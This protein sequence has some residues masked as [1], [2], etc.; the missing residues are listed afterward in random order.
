ME[1]N[2]EQK[3]GKESTNIQVGNISVGLDYND[4]KSICKDIY[5]SELNKLAI[6]AVEIAESRLKEFIDEY[7]KKLSNEKIYDLDEI[8]NPDVQFL[9]YEAQNGYIR[10]GSKSLLE[11]LVTIL[12]ERVKSTNNDLL[13]LHYNE[14]I[15]LI[16]RMT[17]EQIDLITL[18]FLIRYTKNS[19]V[20]D[21]NTLKNYLETYI[22]PFTRIEKITEG[23]IRYLI[24]LGCGNVLLGEKLEVYLEKNYNIFPQNVNVKE[25]ILNIVPE[26]DRVFD[27]W[28]NNNLLY[29]FDLTSVS[30]II[31]CINIRIKLGVIFNVYNW[32]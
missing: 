7:I 21:S 13:N 9:I 1:I 14:A 3:V 12:S 11:T 30:M 25:Y 19:S 23:K 15:K 26:M 24:T 5:S 31:A 32:I 16:P 2:Q 28:N 20:K 10:S 18:V 6:E 17:S 8:R 27:L 22:I 4:V 29:C